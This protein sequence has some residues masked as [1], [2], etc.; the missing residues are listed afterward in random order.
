[1]L[2][3]ILQR[4]EGWGSIKEFEDKWGITGEENERILKKMK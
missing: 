3:S 4:G 1:L 2:L